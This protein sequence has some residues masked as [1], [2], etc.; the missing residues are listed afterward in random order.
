MKANIHPHYRT[1]AFHDTSA[2]EYFM[3]GSTIQTDCTIER[4]GV[5]CPYVTIDVSSASHPYYTWKQKEYAKEGST[6]R[7]NKRFGHFLK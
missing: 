1:V 6:A 7:F 2:D 5:T 4:D 3:V